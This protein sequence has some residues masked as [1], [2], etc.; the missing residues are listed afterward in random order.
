MKLRGAGDE[1]SEVSC[2]AHLDKERWYHLSF[3]YARMT[4]EGA[5]F[6]NGVLKEKAQVATGPDV[7]TSKLQIGRVVRNYFNGL[8][9]EV[10]I[11]NRPRSEEELRELVA[12]RR[13]QILPSKRAEGFPELE[14]D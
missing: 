7:G 2:S 13:A 9:D 8:I 10:R 4:N 5:I 14:W 1:V 11:W 6:I 3:R 12:A